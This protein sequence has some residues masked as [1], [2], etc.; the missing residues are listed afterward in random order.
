MPEQATAAAN[1]GHHVYMAKP[2]AADVPGCLQIEA[3]ARIAQERGLCFVV[4]YQIP[5]D[6]VNIEVVKRI[7][8]GGVGKIVQLASVGITRGC[9]DPPKT[10]NLESRL[11]N[12]IWVNDI[13]MGCDYIGNFDI[14]AVDAALWVMGERPVAATARARLPAP[15]A[16]GDAHGVCSVIYDYADGTVHNHFGQAMPDATDGVLDCHVYGTTGNA[17]ISYWGKAS[18]RAVPGNTAAK[19]RTFTRK[20]S[21]ATSR[22]STRTSP[23]GVLTPRP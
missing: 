23:R 22:H 21:C 4:D 16:H 7:Q 2:V 6:P 15:N 14:H 5:T 11:Q 13:A 20:A 19:S 3:A 17:L 8:D 9:P 18:V 12:L 1:A 10:D